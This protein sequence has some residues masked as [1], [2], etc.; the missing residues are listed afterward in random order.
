MVKAIKA[1]KLT[2]AWS[3]NC[4]HVI[5]CVA[6]KCPGE[7]T[8]DL[9]LKAQAKDNNTAAMLSS[10]GHQLGDPWILPPPFGLLMTNAVYS[11]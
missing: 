2:V 10:L 4:L 8:K 3:L 11:V 7:L 9:T 6:L 1:I 5:V